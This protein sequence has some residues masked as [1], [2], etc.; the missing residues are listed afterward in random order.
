[1]KELQLHRTYLRRPIK[2]IAILMVVVLLVETMTWSLAYPVKMGMVERAG[3]FLQ[4]FGFSLRSLLLPE[5]FTLY[6]LL[7]LLSEFH[8]VFK[9]KSIEASWPA[10][11][12]YE[13]RLL[14]VILLAF[15]VFNPVTQTVRFLLERFPNYS[16]SNYWHTYIAN[17]FTFATYFKYLIPVLLI[18]YAATNLSLFSDY[19]RRR[20]EDENREKAAGTI[21]PQVQL[22]PPEPA[23]ALSRTYTGHLKGRNAH[24]ELDFPV[25]DVYFFTVEERYYYAELSKGRYLISK[26]L[27]DLET[28][29][30]P[31][32]FFRIK[33]DYIVNRRSVLN[34]AYWEN[35]KYIVRLDTPDRHEIV[36][37]RAR[38]QEFR[39][40]LQGSQRSTSADESTGSLVFA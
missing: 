36:V 18:G 6:I 40:W 35:G 33:R 38:M 21:T 23:P 12:R 28:E 27:N 31:F 24:G 14:P 22:S 13:L 8:V 9:I 17:T 29:L 34:Y 16:F 7:T 1:M 5:I 39:E 10:I 37:P 19:L 4:Y 26:T 11:G 32:H 15:F 2:S 30:D 25:T 3:G 20:Q